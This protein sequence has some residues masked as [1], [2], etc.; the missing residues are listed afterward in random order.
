[1]KLFTTIVLTTMTVTA[2]AH[3]PA[4][5]AQYT[6]EETIDIPL[7]E[8]WELF[9]EIP[10]E[11]IASVG[12]YKDLPQIVKTTPVVGDFRVAGDSRRVHFDTGETVLESIIEAK[13]HS[14]FAYEL[15]KVE[16]ELKRAARRARGHFRYETL[17]DGTTKVTWT[18]GFEQKNF[19]FKWFINRYI[20]STHR[21]WMKDTLGELKRLAEAKSRK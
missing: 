9:F 17:P 7:E 6:V 20:Q 21:H 11:D 16:I 12:D 3:I 19:F 15:T 10:L 4:H 8:Y 5:W 13:A 18:Y 1:M 2:S 14:S